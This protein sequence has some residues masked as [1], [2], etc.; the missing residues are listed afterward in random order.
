MGRAHDRFEEDDQNVKQGVCV[1]PGYEEGFAWLAFPVVKVQGY[2]R[3]DVSAHALLSLAHDSG[4][5]NS[6]SFARSKSALG[7]VWPS[8]NLIMYGWPLIDEPVAQ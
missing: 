8:A 6:S 7:T 3:G 2:E 1:V 4:A 5:W